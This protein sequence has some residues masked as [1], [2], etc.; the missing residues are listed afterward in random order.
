VVNQQATLKITPQDLGIHTIGATYSGYS[1]YSLSHVSGT[2]SV[3]ALPPSQDSKDG[4]GGA[5]PPLM[6]GVLA[7]LAGWRRRRAG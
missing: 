6:L 4:G 7:A 2:V 3:L 1:T 5:L